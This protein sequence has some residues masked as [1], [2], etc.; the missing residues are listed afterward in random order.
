VAPKVFGGLEVSRYRLL[1]NARRLVRA[2]VLHVLPRKKTYASDGEDYILLELLASYDLGQA[3]YVDVGANDPVFMSNTYLFYRHGHHGICID[4]NPE[5]A[6]L[7]DMVRSRDVFIA[8]ACA[9]EFSFQRLAG[10]STTT[11]SL[12][13]DSQSPFGRWVA[14]APLDRILE[15]LKKCP[16]FLLSIDTEGHELAVLAG[17]RRTLE[18]TQFVLAESTNPDTDSAIRDL[19][20]QRDFESLG[21]IGLNLLFKNYRKILS[22]TD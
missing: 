1:G 17:A 21:R 4:P 8:A 2:F 15:G 6:P 13:R 18:K 7:Y 5:M 12:T 10:S 9:N 19:M 11:S 3:V 22:R 16:I 14:V 20:F